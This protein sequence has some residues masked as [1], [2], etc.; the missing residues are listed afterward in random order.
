N[1]VIKKQVA[2]ARLYATALGVYEASIN[3]QRVNR[4][5][6]LDPGWTDYTKRVM[7]QTYDVTRLLK[8]GE[9]AVGAVLGDGWYAGRVGWMGLAQYGSRPAFVAQLEITY[10][11]NSTECITTDESWK[12]GAGEIVGSDLQWGEIIDARKSVPWSEPSFDDTSWAPAV[13]EEQNV[14]LEPQRGPPIRELFQL[15]AKRIS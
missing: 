6:V 9:N 1:F 12:A 11:D 10:A 8:Q 14:L 13:V 4:D 2:K 5:S 3:G 15:S 7:V